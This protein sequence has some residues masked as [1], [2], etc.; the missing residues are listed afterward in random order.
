M[1]LE[2]DP[3]LYAGLLQVLR[4]GTAEILEETETGI[5]LRDTVSNGFMLAVENVETGKAWFRKHAHLGYSLVSVFAQELVDFVENAY[6]LREIL[7]CRQALYPQSMPPAVKKSL[8]IRQ[9][10]PSDLDFVL[11]H[12]HRLSAEELTQVIAR[13]NLFLGFQGSQPVGFIGEHLE[14]S[15]GLLEIFPDF[16]QKGYGTE[17]EAFLISH[18]LER[19]LLPYCQVEAGNEKSLALQRKLGMV[20]SG[21]YVYWLF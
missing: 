7:R 3:V 12:Y 2:T 19:N 13:G 11:A 18:M 20:L 17:L 14:G 6:G 21:A 16:R 10:L 15:M 5:F 4:R 1:N 9:A 8:T